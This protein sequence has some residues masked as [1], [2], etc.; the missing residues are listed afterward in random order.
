MQR[1]TL[2]L[3]A[4]HLITLHNILEFMQIVIIKTEVADFLKINIC[5]ILQTDRNKGKGLKMF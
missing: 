2:Q 5:V 1:E 4:I 3:I